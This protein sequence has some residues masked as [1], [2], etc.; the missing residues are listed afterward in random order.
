MTCW[1]GGWF[2]LIMVDEK[3]AWMFRR[4]NDGVIGVWCLKAQTGTKRNETKR[5]FVWSFSFLASSVRPRECSGFACLPAARLPCL[6]VL[7][8][9]PSFVY[10]FLR[11]HV[12]YVA[13]VSFFLLSLS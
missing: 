8:A 3:Q 5:A 9:F 10:F 6:I 11:E 12:R 13:S 1:E 7:T 2:V 4:L